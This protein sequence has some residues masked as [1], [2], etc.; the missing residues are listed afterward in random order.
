RTH[1]I[2]AE[3]TTFGLKLATWAFEL[4]RD[5]A[6]LEQAVATAGVGKISGA[7]G[8]YAHLPS[9]I[10]QYVCDSLGLQVEP[11]SSQ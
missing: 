7:V 4:D 5:R 6:R 9:E 11:A 1:G 10:E 2:W 8:T 3:P